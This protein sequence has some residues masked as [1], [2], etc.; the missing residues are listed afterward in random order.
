MAGVLGQGGGGVS[1][2]SAA[3]VVCDVWGGGA[4][5][6]LPLHGSPPLPGPRALARAQESH[7][8]SA[9]SSFL[10]RARGCSPPA[11]ATSGTH[12]LGVLARRAPGA[13]QA[14]L[15]PASATAAPLARPPPHPR[16]GEA[17]LGPAWPWEGGEK[18]PSPVGVGLPVRSRV[19]LE[20]VSGWPRLQLPEAAPGN[21][22]S[23]SEGPGGTVPSVWGTEGQRGGSLT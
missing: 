14:A 9:A 3:W 15:S 12:Y 23:G 6:P 7:I 18:C 4:A 21:S 17:G 11:P 10:S 1:S 13:V 5:S 16:T 19:G 20:N 22:V 2:I 8:I